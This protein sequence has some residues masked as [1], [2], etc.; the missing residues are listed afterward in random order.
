MIIFI[1]SWFV[2]GFMSMAYCWILDMR[3]KEFD[4]GYFDNGNIALSVFLFCFGYISVL[5]LI[6]FEMNEKKLFT[7]LI[8]KIANIGIPKKNKEMRQ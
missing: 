3:G 5:I 7:R 8:Y 1:I 2:V 6:S 4:P